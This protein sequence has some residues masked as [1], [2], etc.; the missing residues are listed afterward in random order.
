M[1]IEV[2][3]IRTGK[4]TRLVEEAY[5]YI[6]SDDMVGS[7]CIVAYKMQIA[8]NIKN[9]II[10]KIK[11]S[12]SDKSQYNLLSKKI[13]ISTNMF[14]NFLIPK[15]IDRYFIDEFDYL[16]YDKIAF[17]YDSYYTT[18]INPNK[19]IVNNKSFIDYILDKYPNVNR[20][21]K[22]EK[23]LNNKITI[24]EILNNKLNFNIN[25]KIINSNGK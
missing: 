6:L 16:D 11:G 18:S 9:R 10:E 8:K 22:I 20:V 14:E 5:R 2:D 7:I 21:M 17:I 3:D 15:H 19:S 23:L 24:F 25:E 4:T 13:I 12:I 1:F